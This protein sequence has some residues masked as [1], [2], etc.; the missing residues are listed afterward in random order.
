LNFQDLRERL[1]RL[2]NSE[3]DDRAQRTKVIA[4]CVVLGAVLIWIGVNVASML[5][6]GPRAPEQDTPAW[7]MAN[8]LNKQLVERLEFHD[9]MFDIVSESPIK[10]K[11]IGA[12]NEPEDIEALKEFL[13]KIAPDLDYEMAVELMPQDGEPADI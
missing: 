13:K 8:D 5:R 3:S 1:S 7:I 2:L 9:T 11:L 6:S 4:I 12:V 10:L